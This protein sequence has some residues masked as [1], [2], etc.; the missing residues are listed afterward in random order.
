MARNP[1]PKPA[2]TGRAAFSASRMF[3]ELGSVPRR[4][5]TGMVMADDADAKVVLFSAGPGCTEWTRVPEDMVVEYEFVAMARCGDHE[6]PVVHLY[7]RDPRTPAEQAYLLAD[8]GAL[9][10]SLPAPVPQ[11]ALRTA[12]AAALPDG[13]GTS[14]YRS[15]CV[16]DVRLGWVIRN[17][18]IP[19]PG[20]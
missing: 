2:R 11:L 16:Y 17:T 9:A 13:P 5:L 15:D 18:T 8:P 1:P 10:R 3:K 4:V 6:H 12:V 14:G 7:L 19:C 20:A